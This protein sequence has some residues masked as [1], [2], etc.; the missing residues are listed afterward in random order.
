MRMVSQASMSESIFGR[1]AVGPSMTLPFRSASSWTSCLVSQLM[2]LPPLPS[3]SSN[4]PSRRE[5][6]VRLRIVAFDDRDVR[7]GLAGDRAR[8]RPSSSPSA[9]R[10]ARARPACRAGSASI[11]RSCST[12]R[13]SGA[14]SENFFAISRKMFQSLLHLPHRIHRRRQRVDERVHVRRVEVVLLVPGGGRQDDVGIDAGRRHAEVDVDHQ[15]ELPDRRVLVPA[16]RPSAVRGRRFLVGADHA[17]HRADEVLQEIFVALAARAEHV[18]APE[19]HVARPVD[20]IVGIEA[21]EL[22]VARLSGRR[23]QPSPGR[24][25]ALACGRPSSIGLASSCGADGSQPIRS[26]LTL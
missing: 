21:R 9:H 19:E 25:H 15:V 23:R 24:R 11:T 1:P 7:H 5:A 26:A 17:V 20:R 22:E 14:T 8:I 18:R 3:F 2:P 6:R 13:T 16:R 12:P 4:G 10:A